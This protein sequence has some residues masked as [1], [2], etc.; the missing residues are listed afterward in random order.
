MRMLLDEPTPMRTMGD[1]ADYLVGTLPSLD[2][3]L[4]HTVVL[5]LTADTGTHATADS[6][7]S[8]ITSFPSVNVV[9]MVGIAAGVPAPTC[10]DR[11]VRLGDIVVATLGIVDYRHVVH[12][13]DGDELRQPFPRPSALLNRVDRMLQAGEYAQQR[14]WEAWLEPS[15]K[16]ELH[17]FRRPPDD[18]DVLHDTVDPTRVI[19]HPARRLS[20]HRAGWPKVHRGRIGSADVSMR[21]S[22]ERDELAFRYKL[23]AFEMEGAGIGSSGFLN[24]LEWFMVRGISDYGDEHI[25]TRWRRYASLAAAAYIRSLLGATSPV[26]PRGGCP[27]AEGPISERGRK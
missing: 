21:S 22:R 15:H 23:L 5:T 7:K 6:C 25:S 1:R 3:R 24:G 14:P 19:S 2:A 4:D 20:G 8:L 9:I 26:A 18:S 13:A 17:D 10:P 11:H 12:R 27:L 16:V